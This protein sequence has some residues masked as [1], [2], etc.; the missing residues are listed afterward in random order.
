[1]AIP[2]KAG[3]IIY[4]LRIFLAVASVIFFSINLSAKDISVCL[5]CKVQTIQN[6]LTVSTAGDRILIQPGMYKEG[7]LVVNHPVHILGIDF[8]VIDNGFTGNGIEIRADGAI[9]EGLAIQ[10][11]KVSD[12]KEYAGIYLTEVK[13]VHVLNN[14]LSN[15][16]YGIYLEKSQDSR[17]QGNV[18]IGNAVNEI[19]GGNG[20]HL[21]T[22][23]GIQILNNT[24]ID[25]RD[26]LY[27]EFSEDL[28]VQE[29]VAKNCIRYGMHF[30]FSHRSRIENSTFTENS[31]GAAIMYSRSIHLI[32]NVFEKSRGYSSYGILLKDITDGF[33]EGN[34]FENNTVGIFGDSF[35][36]NSITNNKILNN[37]WALQILGSCDQ[38]RFSGNYF[39]DNIF[40]ISTNSKSSQNLFSRNYWSKYEGYDLD[41]D[42]VGDIPHSPVS[43]FSYWVAKYN[44]L[45]I[46]LES[47]VIRFL[48]IA[49]RMFPIMRPES[50]LDEE[51]LLLK[52]GRGND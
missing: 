28:I 47:P 25:H 46:L 42:G 51:P 41:R 5:D 14:R 13:K 29:N 15:N 39:E 1:M 35:T 19:S 30:M 44:V 50:L 40:D 24:M 48:E 32:G 2:Y 37:G 31:T 45:L 22:S 7:D 17:I 6:A 12:I 18:S 20:I 52:R 36:R 34:R 16:A 27:F 8:P 23:H 26:G 3:W 38:N 49:E 11:S 4:H 21:W 43:F 33:M 10:N 9:V